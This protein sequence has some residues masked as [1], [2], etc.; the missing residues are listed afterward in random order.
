MAMKKVQYKQGMDVP[1]DELGAVESLTDAV[2]DEISVAQSVSPAMTAAYFKAVRLYTGILDLDE[3]CGIQFGRTIQVIG[4]QHVGKT[5]FTL[6]AIAAA[7]RTCR[8]CFTPIIEWV[9]DYGVLV[10]D[11]KEW[12]RLT[13]QWSKTRI[14]PF[15]S[16]RTCKCGANQPCRVILIDAEDSFDPYWASLWGVDVGDPALYEDVEYDAA[17]KRGHPWSGIR[18][19]KNEQFIVMRPTSIE[20][21]RK[22]LL[23][24][25]SQSMAELIV[26]DSLA[27]IAVDEELK[28]SD[29]DK[30]TRIGP[31]A[32]ALN[33][34][35]P[36]LLSHR[37]R[38][39]MKSG[40][41]VITMLVNQ[42]RAGPVR[43]PRSDPNR[44]VGGK[45]LQ[46]Y[47]D[48]TLHIT[49]SSVN[50]AIEKGWQER[51]MMRD[52]HFRMD[53]SKAVGSG[54][55]GASG[56]VRFFLDDYKLN[57][58]V[59]YRAGT[60]DDASRLLDFFR[61]IGETEP[62]VFREEK[63]KAYWMFGRPFRRVADIVTFLSR[64][65]VGFMA[66]FI[67][68]ANRLPVSARLHLRGHD[69]GYCPFLDEPMLEVIRSYEPKTGES[70][71][72][73]RKTREDV[74]AAGTPSG[75]SK[76]GADG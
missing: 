64:R 15:P 29:E 37:I 63:G 69:Y 57:E 1:R 43:N 42:Y 52:T 9:D 48:Q 58:K 49:H 12:E 5:L 44:P 21:A 45:G 17:A 72:E 25:M 74:A 23:P 28:G 19:T 56:D 51:A 18:S 50:D 61:E 53:K 24:A 2:G 41:R 68:F 66:R 76:K 4:E 67:V 55:G 6:C 59:T 34:L 32:R 36:L 65:D 11:R 70:L 33:A 22:L 39:A 73:V 20:Q 62:R 35:L 46:Y 14:C 75:K 30:K 16:K 26:V 27:A 71:R 8:S 47:V 10:K 3:F 13:E 7:Q 31:R 40:N 38:G 54:S 60:T